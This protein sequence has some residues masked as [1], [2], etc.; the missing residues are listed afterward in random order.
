[1]E[2]NYAGIAVVPIIIGL[3][4]IFKKI[5]L[6]TK[7]IPIVNLVFGLM[8]G[9]LVLQPTDLIAGIIQGLFIGLS[10]SGLYSSVKNVKEGL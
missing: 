2:M 5:G 10:A 4:E 8:A 6:S 3:A 9:I 7:F 1:M